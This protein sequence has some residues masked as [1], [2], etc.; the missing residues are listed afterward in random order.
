MIDEDFEELKE[1]YNCAEVHDFTED[2]REDIDN[3][4]KYVKNH[5]NHF[6]MEECAKFARKGI[7]WK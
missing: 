7:E 6:D 2:N 5:K 4:V 3:F 1:I